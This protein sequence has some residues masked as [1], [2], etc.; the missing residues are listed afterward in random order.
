MSSIQNGI[1]FPLVFQVNSTVPIT[2][3]VLKSHG[4]Y[5]PNKV[6]GVTT[7]DVVR[8]NSFI[9]EAKVIIIINII[10]YT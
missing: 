7:L 4:V 8:A 9:A 5:N 6:F 3:E 1:V 10:H 2:S